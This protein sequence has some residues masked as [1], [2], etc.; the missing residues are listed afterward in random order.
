MSAAK[1]RQLTRRPWPSAKSD[2]W[3]PINRNTPSRK[4]SY[5]LKF[6]WAV[7]LTLIRTEWKMMSTKTFLVTNRTTL[8]ALAVPNLTLI[9][10][11]PK[12][13]QLKRMNSF[14]IKPGCRFWVTNLGSLHARTNLRMK[15]TYQTQKTHQRSHA[16]PTRY[17]SHVGRL[18]YFPRTMRK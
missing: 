11:Q 16:H 5:S 3:F 8:T 14:T 1:T 13:C 7:N 12:L 2:L 4:S 15:I 18:Y 9:P 10:S 6:K 17:W